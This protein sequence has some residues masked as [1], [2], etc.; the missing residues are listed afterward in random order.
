MNTIVD[1]VTTDAEP[2]A[3]EPIATPT[4]DAMLADLQQTCE[5]LQ[6]AHD[7]MIDP[8]DA[9]RTWTQRQLNAYEAHR[10]QLLQYV[11]ACNNFVWP[12]DKPRAQLV[13]CVPAR[14]RLRPVKA[15]IEQQIAD[16]PDWRTV[17]DP[18]ERDREADRQR[19][20]GDSL[21]AIERGVGYHANT[22]EPAL[23][24]PLRKLLTPPACVT[25]GHVPRVAWVG[26]LPELEAAIAQAEKTIA[27][28]H[29]GI[30]GHIAS[31]KALLDDDGMP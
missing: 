3:V 9:P 13:V 29:E 28:V 12:L 4:T 10:A 15:Q 5:A 22:G 23:P 27:E 24:G 21:V 14:D 18:S 16:A 2:I 19:G 20:L 25:C 7:A 1:D 6:Q 26:P 8:L 30:R 17:A 31:A 11:N